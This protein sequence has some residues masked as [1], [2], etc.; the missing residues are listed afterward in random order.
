ML[1]GPDTPPGIGGVVL[2]DLDERASRD[3][4]VVRVGIS[5]QSLR[6][7][8]DLRFETVPRIDVRFD[9]MDAERGQ[10]HL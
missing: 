4:D 7:A 3:E 5:P 2:D 6:K 1:L 8:V 10:D 9:H